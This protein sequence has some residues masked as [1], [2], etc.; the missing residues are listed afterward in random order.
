ML[1]PPSKCRV[2]GKISKGR[3]YCTRCGTPI[4]RASAR[5]RWWLIL[6]ITLLL[7][8]M[9]FVLS[10]S[11]VGGGGI[12]GR[13][14]IT[15][16]EYNR[17]VTGFLDIDAAYSSTWTCRGVSATQQ[18]SGG[19]VVAPGGCQSPTDGCPFGCGTAAHPMRS[20]QLSRQTPE[21]YTFQHTFLDDKGG[22]VMEYSAPIRTV[23][24]G[25]DEKVRITVSGST[26]H[27]EVSLREHGYDRI[28]T[29]TFTGVRKAN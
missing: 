7:L 10:I 19:Q 28:F 3:Q 2:C 26:M 22:A 25:H 24:A 5:R 1:Q 18:A 4:K 23:P 12:A 17:T 14:L 21:L 6:L 15:K 20:A 13:W 27:G 16:V 11:S 29:A 9:I 8:I